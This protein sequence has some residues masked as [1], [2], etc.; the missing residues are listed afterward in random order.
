VSAPHPFGGA[1]TTCRASIS[2]SAPRCDGEN[3]YNLSGATNAVVWAPVAVMVC[4]LAR[5]DGLDQ[6]RLAD[7]HMDETGRRIEERHVRIFS[8]RPLVACRARADID[9]HQRTIVACH[10]KAAALAIDIDAMG[11]AARKPPVLHLAQAGQAGDKNHR[12][13]ADGEEHALRRGVRHAPSRPA[14]KIERVMASV[15]AEHFELGAV[16]VI[17]D[18]GDDRQTLLRNDGDAIGP[19]AGF[20][21]RQR[22]QAMRIEPSQACRATIGHQHGA[23]VGH[24]ARGFR[25]SRQCRDVFA[26]VVIDDF[27]PVAAG[28][29]DENAPCCRIERSM[30]EFAARSVRYLDHADG[31]ERHDHLEPALPSCRRHQV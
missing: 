9:F 10:I 29:G 3:T 6:A 14:G 11:A 8:N 23:A 30:I 17:A 7:G 26:G 1:V 5:I 20:E 12:R 19:L 16:V 13:V 21:D 28:M 24:D 22:F 27:D 31:F 25:K 4:V 15:A 18:G 2:V